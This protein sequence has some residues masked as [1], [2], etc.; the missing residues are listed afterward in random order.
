[1]PTITFPALPVLPA[2]IQTGLNT[3]LSKALAEGRKI[4]LPPQVTSAASKL[5]NDGLAKAQSSA[6]SFE[7]MLNG[8]KNKTYFKDTSAHISSLNGLGIN[9]SAISST[10]GAS[11][12]NMLIDMA[13]SKAALAHQTMLASSKGEQVTPAMVQSCHA[14]LAVQ[15]NIQKMLTDAAV[16]AK[17]IMANPDPVQAALDIA[18]YSLTLNAQVAAQATTASVAKADTIENLKANAM[19]AMLVRRAPGPQAE[20]IAASVDVTTLNPYTIIKAQRA[21]V[22]QTANNTP[23]IPDKVPIGVDVP[24]KPTVDAVAFRREEPPP[25]PVVAPVPNEKIFDI[26]IKNYMDIILF[27]WKKAFFVHIGLDPYTDP[28]P[29]QILAAGKKA[30]RENRASEMTAAEL[31]IRDQSEAIVAAKPNKSDRTPEELA[32]NDANSKQGDAWRARSD[33]AK[34]LGTANMWYDNNQ[35]D[36]N[37]IYK[38]WIENRSRYTLPTKLESLLV[39]LRTT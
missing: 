34:Y 20:V 5:I 26:E 21:P 9:T 8:V 35:R 16:I 39:T 3:A 13:I 30:Y 10:V 25:A 7:S 15:R 19:L 22:I 31:S 4:G 37:I 24:P 6:P 12:S 14:P 18:A 17:D 2:A 32:I 33:W 27:P 11:Q 29:A 1:M 38:A 36:Y 28:S 23:P